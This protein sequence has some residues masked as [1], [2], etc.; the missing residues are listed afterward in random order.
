MDALGSRS[1][2]A[3]NSRRGAGCGLAERL[4]A[5]NW[6]TRP[7]VNAATNRAARPVADRDTGDDDGRGVLSAR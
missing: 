6:R 4:G 2:A 3:A 7:D 5:S 1:G